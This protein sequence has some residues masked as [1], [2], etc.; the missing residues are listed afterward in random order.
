MQNQLREI[1]FLCRNNLLKVG[2]HAAHFQQQ[3]DSLCF[4]C[5]MLVNDTLVKETFNHIFFTC[6][7]T[8][9]MLTS[10]LT[11]LEAKIDILSENFLKAS[12]YGVAEN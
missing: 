3:V 8:T 10:V 7:V 9:R 5:R 1:I 12:W 6:P 2:A 4:F 11:K